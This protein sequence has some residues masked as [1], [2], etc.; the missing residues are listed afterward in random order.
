MTQ[1]APAPDA[2]HQPPTGPVTPPKP[3][4]PSTERLHAVASLYA[5]I[6]WLLQCT[7]LPMPTDVGLH[8]FDV[9]AP[10]LRELAE[11]YDSPVVEPPRSPGV[12]TTIRIPVPGLDSATITLFGKR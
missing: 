4:K 8:C 5:V 9:P 10:L 12:H 11:R 6:G 3:P 2:G 1:T 7:D